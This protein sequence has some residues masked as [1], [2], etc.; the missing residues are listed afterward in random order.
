MNFRN[1]TPAK[2][3][4]L[5]LTVLVIVVASGY[6]ALM[7]VNRPASTHASYVNGWKEGC[8]SGVNANAPLRLL[9]SNRPFI[10]NAE[11]KNS[12]SDELYRNGWNESFTICRFSQATWGDL[13]ALIFIISIIVC[14]Q[15]YRKN[16]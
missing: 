16:D 8:V 2:A 6:P 14:T 10:Q 3:S 5:I 1:M 11:F 7:M 12:A 15:A 9:F 13:M 4:I